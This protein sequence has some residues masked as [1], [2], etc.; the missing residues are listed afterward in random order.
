[1]LVEENGDEFGDGLLRCPNGNSFVHPIGLGMLLHVIPSTCKQ[2]SDWID[3][4][5]TTLT[6]HAAAATLVEGERALLSG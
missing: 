4:N 5:A 6:M 2:S 3:G 1:M